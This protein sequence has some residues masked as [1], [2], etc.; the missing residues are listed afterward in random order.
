MTTIEWLIGFVFSHFTEIM[1]AVIGFYLGH[2]NGKY[3][4][5]SALKTRLAPFLESQ[6]TTDLEAL[7]SSVTKIQEALTN[8]T[9]PVPPAST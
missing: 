7:K 3:P 8:K 9:P 5:I 1:T 4:W 2:L 6:T